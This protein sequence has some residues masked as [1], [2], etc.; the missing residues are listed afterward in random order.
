M[1]SETPRI[2]RDDISAQLDRLYQGTR[3]H[4]LV[5][6]FGTGVRETIET[7]HAGT[8]YIVPVRSELELRAELPPLA[9]TD[10]RIA[11]LVPWTDS[12]PLDISGRFA[13]AG[14]VF[15]IGREQRLLRMFG[16]TLM[17]RRF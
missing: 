14:R 7:D 8:F 4:H 17:M 10:R 6:F 9:E 2:E 15:R 5:A 12:M 13:R 11:Y 3:K 16:A 1:A